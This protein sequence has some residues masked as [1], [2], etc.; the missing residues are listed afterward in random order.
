[1]AARVE[2]VAGVDRDQAVARSG[3]PTIVAAERPERDNTL[4]AITLLL[5]GGGL[6]MVLSASQA[7]AYLQHRTSLYYFERQAI[8]TVLGLAA[9]VVLS[10]V[11]FHRYRPLVPYGAGLAA[12]A[13]AAVLLPKVGVQINGA[14]RWFDLGPIGLMQPS[15]PAKLALALFLAD[16]LARRGDRLQ[17]LTKGLLPFVAVLSLPIVLLIA[18]RDLGTAAV[19]AVLAVAAYLAAG[20]PKR[21][22]ALLAVAL[23]V[24]FAGFIVLEPYRAARI[25]AFMH[26]FSDELGS[27]FQSSQALIAL[28]SGG[29]TGVGLGNSVEKYLWLPEAH[30]DFIFAIIGEELG[31]VGTTAVLA[32]FVVFSVRGYRAA[33][34]APDRYG[35]IAASAIT[36]WIWFQALMNMATVTST[37]PITGVP[38]P[39]ISYGGT[40]LAITLA[41]VGVL[42]NIA[43]QGRRQALRD[44]WRTDASLDI[45]RRDRRP[46]VS[47]PRRRGGAQ[48]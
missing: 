48:S 6:V 14:R 10:R 2:A 30:T 23:G 29:F 39:F 24:A 33:L 45:G 25:W 19:T 20:A 26:P 15:E 12:L 4:L 43:S 37:L 11:D 9:M 38:L 34:R 42:L 22:L 8:W 46:P 32:G 35:A 31:L 1:M 44:I 47:R 41:A 3:V 36:T 5:L 18:Q 40:A 7:L 28:G 16:W 17:S 13:M 27:G 21:H